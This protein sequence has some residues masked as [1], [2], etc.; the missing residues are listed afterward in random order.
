MELRQWKAHVRKE[1]ASATIQPDTAFAW[2]QEI[3]HATCIEDL[4][5]DGPYPVLNTKVAAAFMGIIRGGELSRRNQHVEDLLAEEGKMIRGRQIA[6]IGLS[7]LSN[8]IPRRL[9]V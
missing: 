1:V 2:W 5:D 6:W 8:H 4:A 7:I 3:E 9:H